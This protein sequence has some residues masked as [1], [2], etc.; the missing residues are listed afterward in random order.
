MVPFY[1]MTGANTY[2]PVESYSNAGEVKE[3]IF[4]KLDLNMQRL[5]YYCLYEICEKSDVIG[6]I[7][8]SIN[9]FAIN[10]VEERFIENNERILDLLSSWEVEKNSS[11]GNKPEF[12]MYLRVRVF[13]PLKENDLD[14]VTMYYTQM[15]YD[16]TNGRLPLKEA[17]ILT[18]A[19]LQLQVDFGDYKGNFDKLL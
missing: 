18:L 9:N 2:V 10:S 15:V 5:P 16:V 3:I 14:T 7:L 19:S 12:K 17:D 13:F 6:I 11:K 8:K 1:F 4:K